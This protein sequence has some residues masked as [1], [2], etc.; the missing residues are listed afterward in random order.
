MDEIIETK[1]TAAPLLD[2]K[3]KTLSWKTATRW[4]SRSDIHD[5]ATIV[6]IAG[7]VAL[8]LGTFRDYAISN[9]EAIQH[10]YGELIVAYY[11]SGFKD[12]GL[13]SFDN[14]Y[15]Y[16]GLFDVVA[17][18]L[19]HL[20]PI[21]PYD[22]R[23]VLCVLIGVGGIGAAAATARLIAGPRAAL[24]TA[25]TL[26][27]C[28]AWY[29][30]MFNHTKDIPF[31]AAM[32]GASFFVIRI[33]RSLPSPRAL[34]IAALGLLTGAALGIRVLGLLL[35][36]YAGMAI[37]LYLPGAQPG[38]SRTGWRF[39]TWSSFRLLPA[40]LLAYVVMILAW[41]WAGLAPFNPIRGLVEF[42]EFQ[43]PIRTVLAGQVYDMANVPRLY[44][45]IYMLVRTPL[46]TLFG[47]A[48]AILFAILPVT[49]P[50]A[51]RRHRKDIALLFLMVTFPLACQAALHGPA[52]TG[53]RH[54]LFVIPPL[55]I[56]AGIGLDSA[57]I[58]L[59][60]RG[61]LVSNSGFAVVSACLIWNAVTLV[62]LHPYEYLFYNSIVGG[63][64]GASRRY[65]LDYWFGSMPEALGQLENFLRATPEGASR[66]WRIYSVAVCGERHSFE[67]TVTLPQLHWDFR[68][69]WEQSDF[70]LAPTHMNCDADLDGKVIG[71]VERLGVTI[72][73]IKDR[74]ALIRPSETA[75]R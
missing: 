58:A 51:R 71:T 11:A 49:A 26:S 67:K 18:V 33:A 30:P 57:L 25:I 17:V 4:I 36:I 10:H 70:F 27:T 74:R 1:V 15:L 62:R 13:F 42:S 16:G 45:P 55:A 5:V 12:Q 43:Y 61:R 59:A 23:H 73:Y 53:L 56:L 14:L 31:A 40:L 2:R 39:V 24:I 64:E 37:M 44:V 47:A 69:T 54:F 52:F 72:A 75:T 48:F 38:R 63:L 41:P 68:S 46:L 8:A 60:K 3:D 65:D 22:L 9:D 28:G 66:P 50:G 6:L 20:V 19:S 7:L 21:D 32:M 35:I 34:D 29:G